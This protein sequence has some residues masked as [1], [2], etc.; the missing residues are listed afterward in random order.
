M[1]APAPRPLRGRSDHGWLA[2]Q[3]EMPEMFSST[4]TD[5]SM[6]RD[7]ALPRHRKRFLCG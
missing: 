7:S 5:L 3:F 2:G 6:N 1:K 4:T